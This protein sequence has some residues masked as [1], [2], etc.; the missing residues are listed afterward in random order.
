ME[1]SCGRGRPLWVET[2]Q[3]LGGDTLCVFRHSR[4]ACWLGPLSGRVRQ[5]ERP[6]GADTCGLSVVAGFY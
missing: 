2:G 6:P 3:S 5:A 1:D 4:E